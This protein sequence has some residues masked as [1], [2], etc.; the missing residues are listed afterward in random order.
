MR[1]GNIGSEKRFGGEPTESPRCGGHRLSPAKRPEFHQLVVFLTVVEA[2]SFT[3]AARLLGLTQPAISQTIA[4]LE[5]VYGGDLFERRRGAPLELTPIAEA[6]L[7]STWALLEAVDQQ[8]IMA[9]QAALSKTGT[10]ILGLS[11]PLASRWMYDGI[12]AFIARCPDVK[13]RLIEDIPNRLLSQLHARL[14]DIVFVPLPLALPDKSLVTETLWSERFLIASPREHPLAQKATVTLEHLSTLRLLIGA[15]DESVVRS[16]LGSSAASAAIDYDVQSVSSDT[17]VDM[18]RLGMGIAIVRGSSATKR[19]QV[20][21]RAI[22][23]HNIAIAVN[24]VWAEADSNPLRHR[25][26]DCIRRASTSAQT[27]PL[28]QIFPPMGQ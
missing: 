20:V 10:I 26:L 5:D 23:D 3:A 17:L 2:R 18:V 16:A 24:A 22:N 27:G 13:L 9:T 6:I 19:D 25:L 21:F 12:S 14:I 28:S 4:R 1:S 15:A 7:P 8:L 11:L